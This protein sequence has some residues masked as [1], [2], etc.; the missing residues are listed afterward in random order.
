M[1]LREFGLKSTGRS[2]GSRRLRGNRSKILGNQPARDPRRFVD[3][4]QPATGMSPSTNQ[5]NTVQIF[6]AIVW[7]LVQ[8]L[9]KAVSHV[10]RGTMM[11]FVAGVPVIGRHDLLETD[12]PIE[13]SEAQFLNLAD[14]IFTKG[15]SLFRPVHIR[16][17]MRN[18][19]KH[20]KSTVNRS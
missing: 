12:S 15:R 10:E 13:V 5:I 17:L 6:K 16:V 18:R 8:H 1:I 7:S 9:T 4:G 20:V 19:H 3:D 14:H 11:Y 2:Q